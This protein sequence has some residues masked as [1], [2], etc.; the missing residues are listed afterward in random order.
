MGR[1]FVKKFTQN[2]SYYFLIWRDMFCM[3]E[4]IG[5]HKHDPSDLAIQLLQSCEGEMS[6]YT[7]GFYSWLCQQPASNSGH[8][9]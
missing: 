1:D 7:P 5:R 3:S 8:S 4:Q 6:C 9:P 2:I